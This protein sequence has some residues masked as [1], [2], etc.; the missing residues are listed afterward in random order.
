MDTS[1]ETILNIKGM[2]C[3][4]CAVVIESELK[5]VSGVEKVKVNLATE[6]A[7][8]SGSAEGKDLIKAVKGAGYGAELSDNDDPEKEMKRKADEIKSMRMKFW[9]SAVLS[10]PMLYFMLLDFFPGL[11]GKGIMPYMGIISLLLTLPIQFAIGS[12]F[13]KGMWS[14]LKMKMF[15]MDALIAMGTTTAFIYSLWRYLVFI[16]ANH[17]LI[18]LGGMKIPDLYFETAAF[19]ITFV[20]LGKLLEAIAK[21]KT[22]EA[23]KKLMGLQPKTARIIKDGKEIEVSISAVIVGDVIV[24][25]PGEKIPLDGTIISGN[26]SVDESMITGESIPVEKNIGDEVTGATINKSGSFQFKVTRVGKDTAL[27]QIIKL[28][29]EAQGSRAPIQNLADR[30]S[31][32]FVPSVLFIAIATFIV[33][34]FF[35]HAGLDFSLMAFTAVIVVACPCALGLA[36]PTAI[37]VGTGKGAEYGVLIKGGEYLEAMEKIDAIVFDKTGTL[38]KGRPEVID[39]VAM[40]GN[41]KKEIISISAGLEKLSEH[42]LSEAVIKYAKD[43]GIAASDCS[44]FLALPGEG[45]KGKVNGRE[46][47]FGN[48][49][50]IEGFNLKIDE[51]RI[52]KLESEGKTVMILA[53]GEKITGLV[54]VADTIK[55]DVPAVVKEL[56]RRGIAV[57]MLTGDSKS[58]AESIGRL[59]GIDNVISNVLPE[60]KEKKIKELQGKGFKVA[61]V[62]DGIND[63]P[64]LAQADLGIAMGSGTDVAVETGGVVIVKN[65]LRD[66][67]TALDLGKETMGKIRQNLFFALF[68][69]VIGIPIAARV[70]VGLGLILKPEFAGL[71]MAFSDISVVGNS[72]LLK[73][74]RPGK[75]NYLSMIA[76]VLMTLFF[77]FVFINFGRLSAGMK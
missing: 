34:F 11:P 57:Y 68:Y 55:E 76:P 38:T 13:Y 59:A 63:A 20:M 28:I 51:E 69:N 54:A 42:P 25:R 21:G 74:F 44:D 16:L 52:E 2:H 70:F 6:K 72:L 35:L 31:S 64:A 14:G 37:M 62:G 29:E 5:K 60:D 24:V 49:K 47:Y 10:L 77:L 75:K 73:Y 15:N 26:S 12:G 18:G 19:L 1:K 61:M 50:I 17:S 23:I 45:V 33:W 56:K 22:S 46:Y 3:A 71:A 36:T 67:L 9:T 39:V 48:R 53:D 27:A 43:S 58:A 32:W 40:D 41:D 66:V 7:Y 65:D 30:V 8:V 4:S